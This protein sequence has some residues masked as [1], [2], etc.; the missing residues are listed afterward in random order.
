VS[1]GDP[2]GSG[3]TDSCRNPT[4]PVGPF[5]VGETRKLIRRETICVLP[6]FARG[7][8]VDDPSRNVDD[9]VIG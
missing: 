2:R 7:H 6:Q 1:L 4:W 5:Q 8:T 3:E 9:A